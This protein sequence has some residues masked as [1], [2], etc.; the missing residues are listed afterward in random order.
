[1]SESEIALKSIDD[2]IKVI[3]KNKSSD[4]T[5]K[6]FVL[7][8]NFID[9]AELINKYNLNKNDLLHFEHNNFYFYNYQFFK[10]TTNTKKNTFATGPASLYGHLVTKL[11]IKGFNIEIRQNPKT[12]YEQN[13]TSKLIYNY[14][15][16][17]YVVLDIETTGLDP[18]IDDIIQIGIFE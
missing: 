5:D 2:L 7:N 3:E 6:T 16:Q 17:D 18:L 9:I 8:G 11:N 12:S 10:I 1:M 13:F 14:E 15:N 4:F